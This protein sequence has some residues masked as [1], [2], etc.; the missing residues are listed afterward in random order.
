[1]KITKIGIPLQTPVFLYESRVQWG[2]LFMKYSSFHPEE[3]FNFVQ[4]NKSIYLDVYVWHFGWESLL[5]KRT[6]NID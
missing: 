4:L 5:H 1:M 3:M 2:I 6:N